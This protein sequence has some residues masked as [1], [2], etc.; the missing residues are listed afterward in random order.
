MIFRVF[1][2]RSLARSVAV[3]AAATAAAACKLLPSPRRGL[4][5]RDGAATAAAAM[6]PASPQI[7]QIGRSTS[8]PPLTSA[9]RLL[10]LL[11][12]SLFLQQWRFDSRC[13]LAAPSPR[14][15]QSP[16]PPLPGSLDRVLAR[17]HSLAHSL[18]RPPARSCRRHSCW[19]G[20]L[21]G[22]R[23][24]ERASAQILRATLVGRSA[25]QQWAGRPAR[26]PGIRLKWL[27]APSKASAAAAV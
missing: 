3:V 10:L 11:L 7:D 14:S 19:P 4:A 20:Q 8:P 2:S 25:E 16:Q 9:R 23:A 26:D 27:S 17:A 6:V 12:L 18:A 15:P 13:L 5:P 1:L 22:Q 21:D 24:S